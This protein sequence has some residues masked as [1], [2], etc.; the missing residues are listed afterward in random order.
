VCADLKR[1]DLARMLI[2]KFPCRQLVLP[3]LFRLWVMRLGGTRGIVLK[4]RPNSTTLEKLNLGTT[5]R[6]RQRGKPDGRR[7]RK[8]RSLGE[9]RDYL[10]VHTFRPEFFT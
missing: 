6:A 7:V 3:T 9:A 5:M 8:R 10:R 4:A 1:K 2:P